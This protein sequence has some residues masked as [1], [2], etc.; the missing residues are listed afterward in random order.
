MPAIFSLIMS[1]NLLDQLLRIRA[2]LVR[3]AASA[4]IFAAHVMVVVRAMVAVV[5]HVMV[6]K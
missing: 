6:V 4:S 1:I 3:N 5:A 2:A